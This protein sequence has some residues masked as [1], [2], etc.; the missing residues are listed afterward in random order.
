MALH[1]CVREASHVIAHEAS[2]CLRKAEQLAQRCRAGAAP[3]PTHSQ[4]GSQAGFLLPLAII[5]ATLLLLASS[6]ALLR[7]DYQ[8]Q[9]ERGKQEQEQA[10]NGPTSSSQPTGNSLQSE[11]S[12][13]LISAAHVYGETMR[14][15]KYLCLMRKPFSDWGNNGCDPNYY[16]SDPLVLKREAETLLPAD[17]QQ[18]VNISSWTPLNARGTMGKLTLTLTTPNN[19]TIT[20][21][22]AV[23][24]GN[25]AGKTSKVYETN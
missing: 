19:T 22:F 2:D 14:S 5:S 23:F 25:E 18:R 4:P 10:Q 16:V 8:V 17:W 24:T 12:D 7:A 3:S 9:I 1:L 20:K 15:F 11:E 13:L 6:V 21:K